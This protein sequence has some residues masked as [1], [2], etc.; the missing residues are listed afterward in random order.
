MLSRQSTIDDCYSEGCE[1]RFILTVA[2]HRGSRY[3]QELDTEL[4]NGSTALPCQSGGFC[5]EEGRLPGKYL[6]L[7]TFMLTHMFPGLAKI[8]RF[9]DIASAAKTA[10]N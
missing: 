1:N 3:L 9:I 7:K 6:T 5:I 4:L 2:K 10:E 8:S